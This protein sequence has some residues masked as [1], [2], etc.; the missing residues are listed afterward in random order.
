M[1]LGQQVETEQSDSDGNTT[2]SYD[3]KIANKST[4]FIITS[5]TFHLKH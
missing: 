2:D 4:Y 1:N 5:L 3:S